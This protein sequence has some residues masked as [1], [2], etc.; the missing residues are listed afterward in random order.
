MVSCG[1]RASRLP[2]PLVL[3]GGLDWTR[4]ECAVLRNLPGEKGRA[5][6]INF[7]FS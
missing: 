6:W 2:L 7:G 1:R 4:G 5:T 3:D